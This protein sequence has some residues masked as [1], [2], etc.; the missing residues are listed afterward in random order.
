MTHFIK[1]SLIVFSM[2]LLPLMIIA[3]NDSSK[4][5]ESET[6]I[7]NPNTLKEAGFYFCFFDCDG[8]SVCGDGFQQTYDYRK[9][10]TPI[11][12]HYLLGSGS[13]L[14]IDL[15]IWDAVVALFSNRLEGSLLDGLCS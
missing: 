7:N 13:V 14:Y 10:G 9:M 4:S 1:I 8:Y 6:I 5:A 12:R 3:Q 2:L 15:Y 11:N